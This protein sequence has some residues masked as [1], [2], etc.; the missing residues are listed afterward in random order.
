MIQPLMMSELTK[1][2]MKKLQLLLWLLL[3]LLLSLMMMMVLLLR[4]ITQFEDH[5]QLLKNWVFW[6]DVMPLRRGNQGDQHGL[7][8]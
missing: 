6:K 4:R 2:M 3:L 8:D 5:E 1:M 7:E